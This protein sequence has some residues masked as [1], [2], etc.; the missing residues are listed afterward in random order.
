MRNSDSAPAPLATA[1][2]K[3]D[4]AL[5]LFGRGIDLIM[6][7][8]EAI[9]QARGTHSPERVHV[10]AAIPRARTEGVKPVGFV[11]LVP[12]GDG[13]VAAI[14]DGVPVTLSEGKAALLAI[15][16]ADDG[17]PVDGLVRWKASS[18]VLARLNQEL[19]LNGATTPDPHNLDVAV[20][21]LR[22]ALASAGLARGLV[23]TSPRRGKRFA[24]RSEAR[25]VARL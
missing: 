23:Q 25:G 3:L 18:D 14:I 5:R 8:Q 15:L 24:I 4:Q 7:A 21:R 9:A 19:A 2:K 22:N 16:A 10:P 20:L 6:E 17:P 12:N 1:S 11:K 13:S